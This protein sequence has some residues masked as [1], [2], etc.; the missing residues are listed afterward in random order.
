MRFQSSFNFSSVHGANFETLTDNN[1][2][3]YVFTTAKLGAT[4]HRWLAE[5]SNC[6]F[7]SYIAVVRKCR[8]TIKG[9]EKGDSYNSVSANDQTCL[10]DSHSWTW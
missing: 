4:W 8:F 7:K 2:L 9:T 6:N 3:T 10:S 1:P 5:L